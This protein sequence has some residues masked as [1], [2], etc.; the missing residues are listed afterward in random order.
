MSQRFFILILFLNVPL[1][2][3][4]VLVIVFTDQPQMIEGELRRGLKERFLVEP[5]FEETNEQPHRDSGGADAGAS[6]ADTRCL[7]NFQRG[8]GGVLCHL[9][10]SSSD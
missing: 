7:A 9:L 4:S 10:Q 8:F 6:S 1:N 2:L 5:L 3:R